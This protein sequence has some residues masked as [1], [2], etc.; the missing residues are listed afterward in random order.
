[1][2][3]ATWTGFVTVGINLEIVPPRRDLQRLASVQAVTRLSRLYL[4]GGTIPPP[5]VL[6]VAALTEDTETG[7]H[8]LC[9][10]R[11][12]IFPVREIVI[13]L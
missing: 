7:I 8:I 2:A 12:A 5:L 3:W 10:E 4:P 9:A 11:N 1:M 6:R 13:D